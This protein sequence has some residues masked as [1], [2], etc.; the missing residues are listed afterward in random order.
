M[1]SPDYLICMN[2]ESPCYIFEW[3]NDEPTEV[4]CEAC[5]NDEPDEFA[6]PEDFE[7]LQDSSA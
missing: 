7:A 6:T 5:G 2:C 1:S 3:K 4:F